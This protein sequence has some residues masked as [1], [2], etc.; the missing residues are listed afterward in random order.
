MNNVVFFH[1]KFVIMNLGDKMEKLNQLTSL[2][3]KDLQIEEILKELNCN[4]KQLLEYLKKLKAINHYFEYHVFDNKNTILTSNYDSNGTGVNIYSHKKILSAIAISDI[5]CGSKS[6]RA[7][8]LDEVYN[9]AIENNIHIIFNLGDLIDGKNSKDPTQK[10]LEKLYQI[11]PYDPSITNI[12]LLGN[13]DYHSFYYDDYDI[14]EDLFINR[15]DFIVTGYG[16]SYVALEKTLIGLHHD[17]S[18]VPNPTLY[19]SAPIYLHGHSHYYKVTTGSS[20]KIMVPTLSNC[21]FFRKNTFPGFLKIDFYFNYD[22]IVKVNIQSK[23]LLDK[24]ITTSELDYSVPV[25][26][27]KK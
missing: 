13:H 2:L 6:E 11:Y 5:H 12:V 20:L 15:D 18:I 3:A 17:L 9:Y 10:Q 4:R 14:S 22:K 8:L 7:D 23:I 24:L 25:L 26:K 21:L 1:E 16:L 19:A 27:K